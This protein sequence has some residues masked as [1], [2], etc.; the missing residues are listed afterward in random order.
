[1]KAPQ[2]Y[3]FMFMKYFHYLTVKMD[4]FPF[5]DI[6]RTII[7]TNHVGSSREAT[8]FTCVCDSVHGGGGVF[9]LSGRLGLPHHIGRKA[10][11][12]L[13]MAK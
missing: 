5:Y 3:T 4:I 12:F 9:L 8:F 13:N 1:M 10:T 7:F 6:I 2:N 11:P